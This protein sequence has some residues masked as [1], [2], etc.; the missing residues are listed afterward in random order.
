MQSN[1]G[2]ETVKECKHNPGDEWEDG[3]CGQDA[4]AKSSS[5]ELLEH[6]EG[7]DSDNGD[8]ALEVQMLNVNKIQK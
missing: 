6:L 1:Q 3:C 7:Q 8:I 2:A 5:E 4:E